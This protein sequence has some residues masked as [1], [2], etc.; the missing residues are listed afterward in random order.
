MKLNVRQEKAV[1]ASNPRV[2]CLASAGSGKA[3]PN[4][5]KIPT[6]NGW[7]RV[8]EIQVGDY[9]FDREGK[10]TKV[11]GV[12]PQGKKEV[13]QLTF[14]DKRTA[15]SSLDH[16]WYVHS[17]GFKDKNKFV[18]KTLRE[19]LEDKWKIV[20][21]RGRVYHK[22]SIPCAAAVQYPKY[23][24]DVDPYTMGAFLK[25]GCSIPEEYKYGSIEQRFSL[26]QGLM[27][28]QGDIVYQEGKYDCIFTTCNPK[29]K[30]D[31]IEVMGSLGY[32]CDYRINK[33]KINKYNARECLEIVINISDSEKY[34]LFS[35]TRKRNLAIHLA[36]QGIN[37]KQNHLYDRTTIVN[38]ED[39]G[40][41]EE[42]T[43][44]LVDNEEHLFLTENFVCTHNTKTLVERVRYLV[45]EQGI[46]PSK[47]VAITYT[48]MA[49]RE[50]KSRLGALVGEMFIGTIHAYANRICSYNNINM[51]AAI[52][53]EEYDK[54]LITAAQFTPRQYPEIEHLLIDEMQDITKL[55]YNF[56]SRIPARNKFFVGDDRQCI[57][58]FKGSSDIYI[59]Q[60]YE[61]TN[62]AKYY[63]TENY[64]N[65]PN[66]VSFANSLLGSY[67]S[68]GLNCEC[69][70]K[71]DGIVEED[72][73]FRETLEMIKDNGNWGSWMV[74]TRLNKELDMA[75]KILQ[76]EGIPCI[77]FKKSDFENNEELNAL[78]QSNNVKVLTIH[79]AKGLE[80]KNVIVIGAKCFNIDEKKI[81]YVAA[82]RAENQLYWCPSIATGKPYKKQTTKKPRVPKQIESDLME[83]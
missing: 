39:L 5:V 19:I 12:F 33:Y 8:D 42:M 34:K 67:R 4:S 1:K 70:K 25:D 76:D 18:C 55:E 69:V 35:L 7:K 57:F 72:C 16:I 49:A 15:K 20:D 61:D 58:A 24:Y 32:V 73:T 80:A 41:E 59:Q 50:M 78:M 74:L 83:F 65:R 38:I 48:N 29:L 79:S 30:D 52:L 13:Y 26:I 68:L 44:F 82:T 47:I 17:R 46:A 66:I 14:G 27:D 56:I 3:L 40:Y 71:E 77:T 54:L 23:D 22:F 9:L 11:L 51:T 60:M 45:E 6:P 2:L 62:Y 43:C 81:A 10:P 53:A 28:T 75:M 31:F 64:R 21:S 63:L 36:L 37:K